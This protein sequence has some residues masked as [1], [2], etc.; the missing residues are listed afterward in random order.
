MDPVRPPSNTNLLTMKFD[1]K[2]LHLTVA[3]APRYQEDSRRAIERRLN[4]LKSK[5]L[6]DA[7]GILLKWNRLRILND[8]G[9]IIEDQPYTFWKIIFWAEIFKPTEGKIVKG[10]VTQIMKSYL[11]AK[12]LDSFTVTISISES[13]STHPIVNN[14]MLEQE[15]Y[16]R[17]KGSSEGVYRAELDEESLA[18]S[19]KIRRKDNSTKDIYHYA[20]NF[21][22]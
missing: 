21:E 10:K 19:S 1:R 22:Y 14:L 6:P 13:A 9:I 12:A 11:L 4:G 15:I 2:E 5:Y 3:I 7:D 16:F 17:I 18:K 8:K 20:K